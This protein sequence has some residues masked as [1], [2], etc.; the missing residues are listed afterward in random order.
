MDALIFIVAVSALIVIVRMTHPR[1]KQD[2][3]VDLTDEW[4]RN[5]SS[6]REKPMDLHA[7]DELVL[8]VKLQ[9]SIKEFEVLKGAN[10]D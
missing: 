2:I 1:E 8:N 7:D 5:P 9:E 3:E 6:R 10:S 4:F